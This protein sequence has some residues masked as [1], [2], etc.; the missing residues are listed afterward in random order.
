MAILNG[1]RPAIEPAPGFATLHP[2]LQLLLHPHLLRLPFGGEPCRGRCAPPYIFC[3]FTRSNCDWSGAVKLHRRARARACDAL[4]PSPLCTC[5]KYSS[6]PAE[7]PHWK[8]SFHD[9]CSRSSPHLIIPWH[10]QNK[11]AAVHSVWHI[12][13]AAELLQL[14]RRWEIV[15][16][17]FESRSPPTYEQDLSK[18]AF[19]WKLILKAT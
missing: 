2:V 15:C 17:N 11:F 12:A 1:E 16:C 6:Q 9:S 5:C 7:F 13:V 8:A 3:L 14:I 4:I 18:T 10:H 19:L